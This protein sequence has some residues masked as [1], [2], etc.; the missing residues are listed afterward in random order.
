MA[1]VRVG[2]QSV[3]NLARSREPDPNSLHPSVEPNVLSG[4][5][6]HLF[7]EKRRNP[8]L[9]QPKIRPYRVRDTKGIRIPPSLLEPDEED[10]EK[11]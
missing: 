3:V 8:L 1:A 6:P 2:Q 5:L 7:G 9:D 4:N 11:E 10:D